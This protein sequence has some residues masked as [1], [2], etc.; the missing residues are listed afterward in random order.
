VNHA[1]RYQAE[2]RGG[3]AVIRELVETLLKLLAPMAPY[4]TEEQ[5]QR[6]GHETSIHKDGWPE[7][8]EAL[9]AEEEVTMI[10]QVNG[11]VR[12]T[13]SVSPD[14]DEAEMKELALSSDKVR[15]YLD[16]GEPSKVVIKPP[17]LVSLVV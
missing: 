14:I 9:A 16:G 13:L 2:G 11:K 6:L 5:W 8:D 12:D 17:K 15:T 7:F 1:Y 3:R 4:I 10:V